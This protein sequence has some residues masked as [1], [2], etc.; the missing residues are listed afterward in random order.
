MKG[1]VNP[2]SLD[3]LAH[4]GFVRLDIHPDGG[5]ARL[6]VLGR[7]D[8]DHAERLRLLYLDA[9]FDEEAQRFFRLRIHG[10][11][12]WDDLEPTFR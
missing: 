5:V 12:E 2:I 6:R 9:L 4:A 1:A 3:R 8:P 11:G 10:V 7:P